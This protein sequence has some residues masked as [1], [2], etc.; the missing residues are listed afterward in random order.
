MAKLT[1]ADRPKL[2]KELTA[3]CDCWDAKKDA[4]TL[5]ALTLD[6]LFQLTNHSKEE[7]ENRDLA[8]SIKDGITDTAGAKLSFNA[9]TGK[10]EAE[11][12]VVKPT[13]NKADDDDDGASRLTAEEQEDLKW[14]RNERAKKRTRLITKLVANFDPDE[15]PD[16]AKKLQKKTL[17]ELEELLDF[18]VNAGPDDDEDDDEDYQDTRNKNRKRKP[19]RYAGAG[20]VANSDDDDDDDMTNNL[21]V[22]PTLD[23][24]DQTGELRKRLEAARS[25][26]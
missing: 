15:R 3:N 11:K 16:R 18:S 5:N 17:S 21:L 1:E 26:S 19:G 8:T 7:A 9:E 12:T 23:F 14:A 6:K 10:W 20:R 2:I 4:D 13:V 24:G 25:A 22:S